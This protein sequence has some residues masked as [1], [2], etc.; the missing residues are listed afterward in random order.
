[1]NNNRF[2]DCKTRVGNIAL[3]QPWWRICVKNREISVKKTFKMIREFPVWE[4]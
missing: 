3:T 1:M 2:Y 4:K